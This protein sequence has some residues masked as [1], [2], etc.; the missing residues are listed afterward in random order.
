MNQLKNRVLTELQK[1]LEAKKE[2]GQNWCKGKK[3][4]NGIEM[5]T[6]NSILGI[7]CSLQANEENEEEGMQK[8]HMEVS[9]SLLI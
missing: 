1:R 3:K 7:K 6:T 8:W 2:N 9:L 4:G 5:E